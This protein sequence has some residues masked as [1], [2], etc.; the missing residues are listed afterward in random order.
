MTNYLGLKTNS[1]GSLNP[2]VY[3]R[4]E[5]KYIYNYTEC[6]NIQILN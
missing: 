6:P 3:A 4:T 2:A 1:N 5:R